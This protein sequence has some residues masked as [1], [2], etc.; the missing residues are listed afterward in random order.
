VSAQTARLA[1]TP[2]PAG[3]PGGPGLY[4]V[5]GMEL[6][7]YFQHIRDALIR[8]GHTPAD[9]YRI[10]WGAIRRWAHGGGKVHPEVVAAAQAALAD[11][12]AKSARAHV[13]S[14]ANEDGAAM[15]L[16]WNGVEGIELGAPLSAERVPPGRRE[17]GQFVPAEP[18]LGRYDTPGQAAR[19]INAMEAAERAVV[20]ASILVPPGF[21]WGP[22]DRLATA[23]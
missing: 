10:T 2:A 19:A 13:Q 9:A 7:P 18:Q 14:H 16:T 17:G 8:S 21:S 22:D 20:R 11:L 4:H 3:K 6:P 12:A 5:A 15:T 1:I 23:Q